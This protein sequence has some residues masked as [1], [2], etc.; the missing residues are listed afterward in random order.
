MP[1]LA[2]MLLGLI[3]IAFAAVLAAADAAISNVSHHEISD[4]AEDG[5]R[6]GTTAAAI[7]AD[8]PTH[9]N[10]LTFVRQFF[11]A[12]ATVFIAVGYYHVF[13]ISW[14]LI[15]A[16][17][18]TASIA[19][20]VVAGVSPRTIGRRRSLKVSLLTGWL[21]A[22]LRRALGPVAR[23]LVWLGNVLTPDKVFRDGPFVT[24][25]QLRDLVERASAV[26]VIE[27]EERDMIE[28]VFNLA[29]TRVYKVM[30][31]RTDIVAI[32]SDQ[33]LVK[34]MELFLR[35]GFSRVPVIDDDLDDVR[36]VVYL[37]D[38]ARRLHLHPEDAEAPVSE[39]CRPVV[40][41]PETKPVDELMREMQLASN[42]VALAVDEYGG[43][44]GL[45]TMED[46]VEEIVGEIEDEYDAAEDDIVET[47]P[48]EYLVSTR[49]QIDDLA[50]FFDTRIEDE[51]VTT[52][53]G[54]LSKAIDRVPIAGAHATISGLYIEAMPGQGRRH[55]ITHVRVRRERETEDV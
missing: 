14:Q 41:V 36:G 26:D 8:L 38:V 22:G 6:G 7:L 52:V 39:H 9:I 44:A 46:I 17:V 34:A 13:G 49:T 10:V 45:I 2:F 4:A 30:V 32:D 19:V 29:D 3:C 48:G 28:S 31:P 21:V 35:S 24:E 51:D 15:L 1:I 42:H 55:R 20:F 11:E 18:I 33:P 37:K 54:L 40:F 5:T 47:A 16:S 43:T 50:E 27:D 23:I 25:E 53:G 12:L